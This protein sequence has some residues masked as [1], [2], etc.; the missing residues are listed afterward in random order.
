[1]KSLRTFLNEQHILWEQRIP[2]RLP[3]GKNLM[4]AGV[5]DL[6]KDD[7][8]DLS[9]RVDLPSMKRNRKSFELSM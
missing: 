7:P 1:M 3:G 5:R 4:K 2:T 8:S 6:T 9:L